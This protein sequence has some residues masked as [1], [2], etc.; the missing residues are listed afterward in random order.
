MKHFFGLILVIVLFGSCKQGESS[1]DTAANMADST[2]ITATTETAAT[3]DG[4]IK[5]FSTEVGKMVKADDLMKKGNLSARLQK[6]MGEDYN[7][8]VANWSEE[9]PLKQDS[10]LLYAIGCKQG[11]CVS[12]K[13]FLLLDMEG[14]NINVHHF[15]GTKVKTWEEGPIIGLTANASDDYQKLREAQ[16]L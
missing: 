9:T 2:G 13:Y 11:D 6:M 10:E 16:G 14:N 15:M 1:T 3:P 12:N 7:D 5:D 8:F 4:N